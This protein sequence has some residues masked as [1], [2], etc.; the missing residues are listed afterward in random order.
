MSIPQYLK[1][2]VLVY[3]T[4]TADLHS[5]V[6]EIGF[7]L[8]QNTKLVKEW[9]TFVR[10]TIPINPEASA[11]HKIYDRDV[12][13]APTFAEIA[14]W[15]MNILTIYDV[16]CAYNY[17]YD[18]KV[19]ER[20]FAKLNLQFP[21]KPMID[22]FILFKKWNKYN[23]GK[24]LID[25]A[26]KYGI[27]YAGAHRAMNDSTVTGRVLFKMAAVKTAFPKTLDKFITTQRQWI[28]EQHLDFSAYRQSRGQELPTPPNFL[29]YEVPA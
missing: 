27:P 4:E 19:L 28:E 10:P 18:R 1:G 17:D 3:D 16:H 20:E 9:G 25:A 8:F 29:F 11:V 2:S 24:K 13:D 14:W 21:V 23:K 6:I 22:P 26:A 5:D 15:V 12:E 7:S